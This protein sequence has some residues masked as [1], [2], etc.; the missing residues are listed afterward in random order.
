MKIEGIRF[1]VKAGPMSFNSYVV[2]PIEW[3]SDIEDHVQPH[4]DWTYK[5]KLNGTHV[6]L[7][8]DYAHGPDEVF[9]RLTKS[10]MVFGSNLKPWYDKEVICETFS[11]VCEILELTSCK[12]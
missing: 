12:P 9:N 10:Y 4:G 3:V 6:Q 1:L 7:G 11:I 5:R 2:V 8:W